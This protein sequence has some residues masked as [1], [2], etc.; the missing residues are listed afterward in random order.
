MAR[1]EAKLNLKAVLEFE[2]KKRSHNEVFEKIWYT[3]RADTFIEEMLEERIKL[4]EAY[5]QEE[6]LNSDIVEEI[7]DN[8]N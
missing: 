3:R 4:Y 8:E 6:K 1:T 2:V 5:E 7:D